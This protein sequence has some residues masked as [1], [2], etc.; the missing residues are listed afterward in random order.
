MSGLSERVKQNSRKSLK[1]ICFVNNTK[2]YLI[3]FLSVFCFTCSPIVHAN[4]I[5]AK[6]RCQNSLKAI[7][8][9][10]LGLYLSVLMNIYDGYRLKIEFFALYGLAERVQTSGFVKQI[11]TASLW[12]TVVH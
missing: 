3:G 7:A 2:H 9:M 6:K 10:V 12:F 8:A 1:Y 11:F 5:M 4:Q